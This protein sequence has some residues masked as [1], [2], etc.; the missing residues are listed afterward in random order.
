MEIT[1]DA[2]DLLT[3][4]AQGTSLRYAMH[5]IMAANLVCLKRKGSEVD[6]DDIRRVYSLFIDVKVRA[7]TNLT[8]VSLICMLTHIP[9]P[10]QRS[11]R[12]LIEYQK[13]FMF[14]ELGDDEG[15]EEGEDEA[16]DDDDDADDDD[17]DAAMAA[18]DGASASAAAP[19]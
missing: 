9:E 6:V 5:I 4:I 15:E 7:K 10:V 14:N 17:G 12:F 1:D 16:D 19:A 13:Q 18:A 11:T 8:I 2:L 3:R